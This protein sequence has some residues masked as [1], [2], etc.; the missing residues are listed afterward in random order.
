MITRKQTTRARKH[1]LKYIKSGEWEKEFIQAE[2]DE[3]ID[4]MI[5][6]SLK[7]G[8]SEDLR[9]WAKYRISI[10]KGEKRN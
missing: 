7:W 6:L 3:D 8:L 5:L 9:E 1:A 4:I 2:K 10:V